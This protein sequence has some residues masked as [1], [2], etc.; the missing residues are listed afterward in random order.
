MN[1]D[2]KDLI[3]KAY[4]EKDGVVEVAISQEVYD[5]LYGSDGMVNANKYLYEKDG[6]ITI[7]L[8][9]ALKPNAGILFKGRKDIPL[10]H[11]VF[12]YCDL[13]NG[14]IGLS[15][16]SIVKD[17]CDY[18]DKTK[19]KDRWSDGQFKK[20]IITHAN[21]FDGLGVVFSALDALDYNRY[22]E[23]DIIYVDYNQ[24]DINDITSRVK[25][26]VVFVGD[27]SFPLEDLNLIK[28]SALDFLLIDH[29][30]SAFDR[31]T[32]EYTKCIFDMGNSGAVL[33]YQFFNNDLEE[34]PALIECIGDR[35]VWNWFHGSM[36]NAVSLYLNSIKS[37]LNGFISSKLPILMNPHNLISTNDLE[38]EIEPFKAVVEAEQAR[39]NEVVEKYNPDVFMLDD[40]E[41]YGI[42]TTEKSVSE[43]L[44]RISSKFDKPTMS[45][46]VAGNMLYLS[47]RS[48]NDDIR[49]N[50]IA[51]VY[52]GGGHPRASGINLSL[53]DIDLSMFMLGDVL[54]DATVKRL[55]LKGK[56]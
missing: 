51:G 3:K 25:D 21:C 1:Q 22:S 45:W 36:T 48:T 4:E 7:D 12:D 10:R 43:I 26:A 47:L 9:K 49:V 35:D 39:I 2:L 56:R 33:A 15:G 34:I 30:Q 54:Y 17:Y 52:G 18:E 32:P 6:V 50:E 11:H 46:R 41:F 40:I 42:N 14:V 16:L 19:F 20:V 29:H 37:G 13:E 27:F 38:E 8:T 28:E 53:D 55:K 44:N 5:Y 31:A 24:Y 23:L